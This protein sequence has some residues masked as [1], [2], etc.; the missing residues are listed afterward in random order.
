MMLQT[1]TQMQIQTQPPYARCGAEPIRPVRAIAPRPR[2]RRN[3][4]LLLTLA[5]VIVAGFLLGL[6]LPAHP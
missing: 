3:R 5:L 4:K 2:P 6:G 1:R